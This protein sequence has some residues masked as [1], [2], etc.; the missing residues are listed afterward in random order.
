MENINKRKKKLYFI[1]K[2]MIFTKLPNPIRET[3]VL[4]L[5]LITRLCLKFWALKCTLCTV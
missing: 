4:K 3:Q 2:I 1:T 5:V